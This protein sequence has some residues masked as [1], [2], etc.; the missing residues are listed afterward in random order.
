MNACNFE[1]VTYD[2]QVFCVPC[3]PDHLNT[4][5]EEVYPVFA[6]SEWDYYPVCDH[7]GREHDYVILTVYGLRQEWLRALPRDLQQLVEEN[8]GQLPVFAWPGGYPLFYLDSEN[9]VL[10][11][12]CANRGHEYSTDLV[13]VDVHWEGEPLVC[14]NCNAEIPAAYADES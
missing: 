12:A 14:E 2:A 8:D 3:L 13:A 11:P 7:C 9:A 10:C 6:S 4:D 5:S 1:A